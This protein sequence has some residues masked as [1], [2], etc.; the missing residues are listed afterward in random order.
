MPRDGE[1]L[2]P[3][4]EAVARPPATIA[5][6]GDTAILALLGIFTM[7]DAVLVVLWGLM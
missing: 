5:G 4:G 6:S 2:L 3:P 7:F 1:S